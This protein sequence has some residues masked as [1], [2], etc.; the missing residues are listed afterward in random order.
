MD[1][2]DVG[3]MA[4][5]EHPNVAGV[6]VLVVGI[7][8]GVIRGG[9]GGELGLVVGHGAGG[10]GGLLLRSCPDFSGWQ[11]PVVRSLFLYLCIHLHDAA[12]LAALPVVGDNKAV[13]R[14]AAVH[15]F[16]ALFDGDDFHGVDL[17]MMAKTLSL[18]M[19]TG[20][21]ALLVHLGASCS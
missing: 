19:H 2:D 5:H 4:V 12:T 16:E 7:A 1:F 20:T 14:F 17:M 10:G 21:M 15:D 8:G 11:L 6:P 18:I 3:G 9:Q 13:E